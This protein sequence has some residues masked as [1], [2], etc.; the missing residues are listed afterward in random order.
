MT[1]GQGR[2]IEEHLWTTLLTGG[3]AVTIAA[4]ALSPRAALGALERYAADNYGGVPTLHIGRAVV[5]FFDDLQVAPDGS[6]R[7]VQ[8]SKI[9]NGAGYSTNLS[10]AGAPPAAGEAWMYVTGEVT[11][12]LGPVV[13][14]A[15]PVLVTNR[16]LALAER[17]V[18]VTA[19]CILG[20]VRVTLAGA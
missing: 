2:A 4:T 15:A 3:T 10:P 19:E 16:T 13:E 11:V 7:T 18:V 14:A 20:A 9:A 6:L 8:G 1:L 5:P 17:A 12:R